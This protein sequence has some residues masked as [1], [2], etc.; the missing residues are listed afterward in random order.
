VRC[1]GWWVIARVHSAGAMLNKPSMALTRLDVRNTR[2][3]LAWKSWVS[4]L[5][6]LYFLNSTA[7]PRDLFQTTSAPAG[8]LPQACVFDDAYY[9]GCA[10]WASACLNVTKCLQ[11]MP[12]ASPVNASWYESQSSIGEMRVLQETTLPSSAQRTMSSVYSKNVPLTGNTTRVLLVVPGI[13]TNGV[14][15]ETFF[16]CNS[17]ANGTCVQSTVFP[18]SSDSSLPPAPYGLDLTTAKVSGSDVTTLC[19]FRISFQQYW[20]EIY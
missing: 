10:A 6:S 18:H 1:G 12:V 9:V 19:H 4:S 17:S 3:S 5:Q 14:P 2:L 13:A 11:T 15:A 16:A 20:K 7:A 8:G